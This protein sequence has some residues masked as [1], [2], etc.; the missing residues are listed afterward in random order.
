MTSNTVRGF[1]QKPRPASEAQPADIQPKRQAVASPPSARVAA[2]LARHD[3]LVLAAQAVWLLSILLYLSGN[4]MP[5]APLHH[6][7]L[8][9]VIDVP[10]A[11]ADDLTAQGLHVPSAM[12]LAQERLLRGLPLAAPL[13]PGMGPNYFP[14]L[15]F[16]V[17]IEWLG[18]TAV[19]AALRRQW[20]YY[21]VLAGLMAVPGELFG[22]HLNM[23]TP[24][25]GLSGAIAVGST[26]W[27]RQYKI[28]V[29]ALATGVAL[30]AWQAYNI[31]TDTN[32]PII[33]LPR[34]DSSLP[35]PP[36]DTYDAALASA[37]TRY[38]ASVAYVRAQAAYL[39]HDWARVRAIGPIDGRAF[40][41]SPFKAARLKTLAQTLH[42]LARPAGAPLARPP[43]A[44]FMV[45][46]QIGLAGLAIVLSLMAWHIR[47]R[48]RRVAALEAKLSTARTAAAA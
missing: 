2:I 41:G 1:G 15:G 12:G 10:Q 30:I 32:R 25:A 22:C 5:T 21:F 9:P 31:N 14:A 6:D 37:A 18:L 13:L 36:F 47:R 23:V 16:M 48:S 35:L 44:V 19:V 43:L 3:W 24:M 34:A 7:D 45:R 33:P 27:H 29:A 8:L 11:L 39:D 28:L 26:L 4:L 42:D 20:R 17:Y 46:L 40:G 38:S